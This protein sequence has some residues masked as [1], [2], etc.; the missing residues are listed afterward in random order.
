MTSEEL[1][2]A[3]DRLQKEKNNFPASPK[4]RSAHSGDVKP[5]TSEYSRETGRLNESAKPRTSKSSRG[6]P[7]RLPSYVFCVENSEREVWVRK[8][9]LEN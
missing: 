7:A 9:C 4:R 1:K 5:A 3:T 2:N 8:E 6:G